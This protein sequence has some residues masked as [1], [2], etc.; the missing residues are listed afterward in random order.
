MN[1]S[2]WLLVLIFI[3]YTIGIFVVVGASANGTRFLG[4]DM[5]CL[6]LPLRILIVL[7]AMT[8][9]FVLLPVAF[10]RGDR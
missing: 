2:E 1:P 10:P 7:L 6:L 9:W 4:D 8:F 5:G 3:Y